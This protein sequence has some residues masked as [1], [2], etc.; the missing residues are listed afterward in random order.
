MDIETNLGFPMQNITTPGTDLL[1]FLEVEYQKLLEMTVL[2]PPNIFLEVE[3]HHGFREKKQG[4]LRDALISTSFSDL[5]K[6]INLST[7]DY[8]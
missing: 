3:K 4:T 2:I 8:R 6:L 7:I 5:T 1:I